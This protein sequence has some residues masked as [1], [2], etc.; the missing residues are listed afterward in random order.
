M[1]ELPT[2][3]RKPT[4]VTD[5][6]RTGTLIRYETKY[7]VR[8]AVVQWDGKGFIDRACPHTLTQV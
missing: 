2:G 1:S 6:S 4:R 7:R 8:W 5:G 3:G